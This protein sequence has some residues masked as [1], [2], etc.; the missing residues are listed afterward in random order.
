MELKSDEHDW[1]AID[2]NYE[3]VGRFAVRKLFEILN[4]TASSSL[5]NVVT[6][7]IVE[8]RWNKKLSLS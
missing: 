3:I 6:A 1:S 2:Q 5:K 8:P 4:A 7:T